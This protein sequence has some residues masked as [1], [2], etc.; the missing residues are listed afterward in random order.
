M[1]LDEFLCLSVPLAQQ[2]VPAS[3]DPRRERILAGRQRPRPCP[4]MRLKN[5]PGADRRYR[6][7]RA[8]LPAGAR[9]T[10]APKSP[11]LYEDDDVLVVDKPAGLAVEPERWARGEACLAGALLELSLDPRG[12]PLAPSAAGSRARR[13]RS[14][15][16]D[17]CTVSTRR[18]PG[19]SSSRRHLESGAGRLRDRL[20]G[21]CTDPT[22]PISRWSRESI[23]SPD[24]ESPKCSTCPIAPDRRRTG[25]HAWSVREA[26][27]SPPS[28]R[29]SS[30]E[31]AL[32]RIH[33]D[34]LLAD[35]GADASDP[36]AH[37]ATS[38]SRCA[39]TVCTAVATS[40]IL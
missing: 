23:R 19:W 4:T 5:E 14:S 11:V 1:E 18:P 8:E 33:V 21:R 28:T 34:A 9:R 35:H 25:P 37:A 7:I 40:F 10:E 15:G 27:A 26:A 13:A 38:V 32:P 29:V 2:G 31:R 12:A 6:R 17:S 39:W 36:R 22:R 24:G 20:R 16:R 30:M 3:S